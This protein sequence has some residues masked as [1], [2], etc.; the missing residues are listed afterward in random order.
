MYI[1]VA[2]DFQGILG[3]DLLKNTLASCLLEGF[4]PGLY[5]EFFVYL[6]Y[7]R[8]DCMRADKHGFTDLFITKPL[9]NS[10]NNLFFFWCKEVLDVCSLILKLL[11]YCTCYL[12]THWCA[13]LIQS[14]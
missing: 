7:M 10:L 1:T 9:F 8:M 5:L 4:L 3:N 13:T 14:I 11:Y 12:G 6:F 2:G